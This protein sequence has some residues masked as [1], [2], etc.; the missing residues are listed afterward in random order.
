MKP[1]HVWELASRLGSIAKFR[2]VLANSQINDLASWGKSI[3][4]AIRL[5]AIHITSILGSRA[6][7]NVILVSRLYNVTN[8]VSMHAFDFSSPNLILR[9]VGTLYFT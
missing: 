2:T 1:L 5:A 7:F 4:L 9:I 6:S 3:R 8:Q